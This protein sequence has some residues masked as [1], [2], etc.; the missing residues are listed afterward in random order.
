MPDGIPDDLIERTQRMLEYR[1]APERTVQNLR[2]W[3]RNNACMAREETAYLDQAGDLVSI[4]S[5]KDD[6]LDMV[7]EVLEDA[8]VRFCG[9]RRKVCRILALTANA[10]PSGP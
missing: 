4:V 1:P 5:P 8:F 3:T 7:E 6:A 9:P 10:Q 2:E